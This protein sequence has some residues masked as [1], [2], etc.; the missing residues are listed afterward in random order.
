MS[1]VKSDSS[2]RREIYLRG[3]KQAIKMKKKELENGERVFQCSEQTS[4]DLEAD[5]ILYLAV[6]SMHIKNKKSNINH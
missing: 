4:H 5:F 6:K 1:R 2:K 3:K